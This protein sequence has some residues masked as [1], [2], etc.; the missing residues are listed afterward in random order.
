M[1]KLQRKTKQNIIRFPSSRRERRKI[2]KETKD[3]RIRIVATLR[4]ACGWMLMIAIVSFLISNLHLLAPSSI[5]NIISYAAAGF[6][7]HKQDIA[8][9]S[10]QNGLI[11]DAALFESGLA[12]ADSDSLFIAKPGGLI[13]QRQQLGYTS[14]TVETSRKHVLVYDRGGTKATLL[15]PT[16]SPAALELDATIITGC[17]ADDGSFA[18]ITDEQGYRTSVAVYN[19][20]AKEV[21]KYRSSEY[22][23]VSAAL[24]SNSKNLAVLAFKQNGVALESH[25]LLYSVA[26]GDLIT[27]AV[28]PNALGLEV[29]F[30]SNQTVAALC[31]DGL[32]TI[33]RKGEVVHDLTF[34]AND[35][36]AFS[37]QNG[38][39]AL[40][41]RSYSSGARS[42]LHAKYANGSLSGP[43]PLSDE[44]SAVAISK[45]GIAVLSTAGVTVYD[46][47]GTP[48]WHNPEAVGAR[49]ILLDDN[50]TLFALYTKYTR[51][52]TAHSEQSEDIAHAN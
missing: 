17:I 43:Y 25:L 1:N 34:T 16:G 51:L 30:L 18:L 13:T 39:V 46:A 20:Q 2:L 40:A 28:L 35:L 36:L 49:R 6:Q 27:D 50:G 23:I 22:Y 41:T 5:R 32:Y 24:S 29:C 26:N 15:G 33:N 38:A 8:T 11:S 14:P 37:I 9:I 42:E 48:L 45:M 52:F 21:F 12:Y 31:D 19:T 10:Y 4:I 3:M 44:P 47:N 7:Q